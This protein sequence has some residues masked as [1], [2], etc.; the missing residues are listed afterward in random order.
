MT[1]VRYDLEQVL[2]RGVRIFSG[3]ERVMSLKEVFVEQISVTQQEPSAHISIPAPLK[4][5]GLLLWF[6]CRLIAELVV[7]FA[8]VGGPAILYFRIL[9]VLQMEYGFVSYNIFTTAIGLVIMIGSFGMYFHFKERLSRLSDRFWSWSPWENF[10]L[11]SLRR[12]RRRIEESYET[13]DGN[14]LCADFL[15]W[16]SE[17]HRAGYVNVFELPESHPLMIEYASLEERLCYLLQLDTSVPERV[18]RLILREDWDLFYNKRP[19]SEYFL[20]ELQQEESRFPVDELAE[21][22]ARRKRRNVEK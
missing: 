14:A 17:L 2:L 7:Y 9:H 16:E 15:T 19:S 21:I 12:H 22:Q 3:S 13:S 8:L 1:Q 20:P 10:R 6:C 4:R 5:A 11:F 18:E